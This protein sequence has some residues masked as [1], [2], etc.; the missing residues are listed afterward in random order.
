M[1]VSI[2]P[3][4]IDTVANIFSAD[5]VG[6]RPPWTRMF[7]LDTRKVPEQYLDGVPVTDQIELM[8]AS[9]VG[10]AILAATKIGREGLPGSWHLNPKHVLDAVDRYPESFSAQ[11]GIDPYHGMSGVRELE[12][13]V[14]EHNVIGAHLYPHWFE[15]EP[16]HRKYY[17][18]YAKCAEL[19]IPIQIQVGNCLRYSDARP[20][21]TVG[22]PLLIDTIACDFPELKI[23][24]TH[25]GWP[26]VEELIAVSY[27][28][29]NVYV[30]AESYAPKF[31]PKEFVHFVNSWGSRKTLF[32]SMWPTMTYQRLMS[33]INALD[34]RSE[35][36]DRFL[37]RN[38]A[39]V[40][41]LPVA[42]PSG[43]ES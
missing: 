16:D 14:R 4:A 31:W 10:H 24:A 2:A 32:A 33:E 3:G 41:R 29:P 6:Q 5:V 13:L 21:R 27:K 30:S 11:V 8:R 20:L 15:L 42:G 39:E 43:R 25:L 19:D 17:P 36:R 26:W 35:S 18:F 23:V 34:L 28:H 37:T 1:T 7:Y 9:G 22:R 40:Y 12:S 38:A